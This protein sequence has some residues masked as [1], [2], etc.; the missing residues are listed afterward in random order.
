MGPTGAQVT[1]LAQ[2]VFVCREK[3]GLSQQALGDAI[4]MSQDWVFRIEAGTLTPS[5]YR[6]QDLAEALQV[7][8]EWLLLGE[9]NGQ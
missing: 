6:A 1:S 9:P 5:A 4:G 3:L 8:L 7:D 2:R